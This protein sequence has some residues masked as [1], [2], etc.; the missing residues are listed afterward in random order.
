MQNSC[1]NTG[2]NSVSLTQETAEPVTVEIASQDATENREC[3]EMDD[4]ICYFEI[5]DHDDSLIQKSASP[6]SAVCI[7]DGSVK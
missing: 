7:D 4:E 2:E 6:Y 1:S 5:T 3:S